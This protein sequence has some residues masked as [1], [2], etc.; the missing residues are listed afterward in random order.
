MAVVHD[1]EREAAASATNLA[2]TM[3]Q[4]LTPALTGWVMQAVALSA[5]FVLGGVLKIVYD[6]ALFRTFRHVPLR[7]EHD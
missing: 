2:R 7:A 5:P 3:A 6:L 4:A 1:A